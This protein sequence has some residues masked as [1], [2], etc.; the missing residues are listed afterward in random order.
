MMLAMIFLGILLIRRA[1]YEQNY[2]KVHLQRI[3]LSV[4]HNSLHFLNWL[5]S[6]LGTH[7]YTA[8]ACTAE[9]WSSRGAVR[10]RSKAII[11]IPWSA[12]LCIHGASSESPY[13]GQQAMYRGLPG[14]VWL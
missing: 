10:W 5:P 6:A 13:L 4:C 2:M 14:I 12:V 9:S 8:I 3:M 1:R 7:T 11:T